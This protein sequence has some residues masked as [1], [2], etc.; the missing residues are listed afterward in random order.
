MP[1]ESH[2]DIE[3]GRVYSAEEAIQY[4]RELHSK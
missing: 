4:L 3:A 1:L 2:A